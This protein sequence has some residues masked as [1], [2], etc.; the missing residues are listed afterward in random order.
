MHFI[1]V[2]CAYCAF[3]D[4]YLVLGILCRVTAISDEDQGTHRHEQDILLGSYLYQSMLCSVH[5]LGWL[6]YGCYLSYYT[7]APLV[8]AWS[9]FFSKLFVS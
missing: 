3:P 4:T 5:P 6:H 8:Q 9:I 7:F 1:S 2:V